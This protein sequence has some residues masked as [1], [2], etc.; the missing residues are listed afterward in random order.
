MTTPD[1][2]PEVKR[3]TVDVAALVEMVAG[4]IAETLAALLPTIKMLLAEIEEQRG[5]L[6]EIEEL[7]GRLAELR[8]LGPYDQPAD[9]LAVLE[10]LLPGWP[11]RRCFS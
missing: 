6:A 7:R 8:C 10:I 9:V 3:L 1:A 2:S 11:A 5:Q 4:L